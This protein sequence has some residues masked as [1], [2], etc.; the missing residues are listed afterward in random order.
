M[1]DDS[2]LRWMRHAL[3]LAQQAEAAG[4]V[5]VGAVLVRDGEI[6]GEGW[7][8]PIGLHDP[9]AHAEMLALR[10]AGTKL[11]NYRLTGA[12]LYVTLEPCV[13]CAGAMIHAR[14]DRLVFGAYDP[15]AGAVSSVYDVLTVPRLNHSLACEGG[16]LEQ[17]CSELLRSFF[18]KRR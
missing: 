4:E 6:I 12:T 18:R 7:N 16:V 3:T 9:S 2:D 10:S 8:Q 1:A 13:M 5:P 11:Q 14:I 15:K 17:E